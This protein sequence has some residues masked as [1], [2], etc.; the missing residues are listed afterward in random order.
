M[1]YLILNKKQSSPVKSYISAIKLVLADA[2]IK[3]NEDPFLITSLTKACKL[4]NDMVRTCFP[5]QKGMLAI[6]IQQVNHHFSAAGQPYLQLLYQ[7][8][9]LSMYFGLL[10]VSEVAKG[11]HPIL[12]QDIHVGTNKKKMLFVLRSSKTHWK[13]TKP[14]QVKISA[15]GK[16]KGCNKIQPSITQ[17]ALPIM[18][19]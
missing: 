5:I 3:L 15:T 8:V 17:H 18:I 2:N 7:M 4:T 13:N 9:F 14:Q 19:S 10:R 11:A 1:G 16:S 12:A 6:L